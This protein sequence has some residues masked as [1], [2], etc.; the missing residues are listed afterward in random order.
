MDFFNSKIKP[1]ITKFSDTELVNICLKSNEI[2]QTNTQ[3]KDMQREDLIKQVNMIWN[4]LC[5]GPDIDCPICLEVITNQDNMITNCG[6]YFHSSCM[7]KYIVKTKL[8]NNCIGCPKCRT[9]IYIEESNQ[10]IEQIELVESVESIESIEY[11]NNNFSN[12][13][14]YFD[15]GGYPINLYTGFWTNTNTNI[16]TNT[17]T[18]TELTLEGFLLNNINFYSNSINLHQLNENN[19]ISDS[20]VDLEE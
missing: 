16:N 1:D 7:I 5:I 17:N 19:N 3:I 15:N 13:L 18:N 2:T 4:N 10:N 9:N 14:E 6:H 11:D 8:N 20:D 12:M